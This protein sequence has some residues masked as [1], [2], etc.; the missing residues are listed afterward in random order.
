MDVWE[1]RGDKGRKER[2]GGV[3]RKGQGFERKERKMGGL[4]GNRKGK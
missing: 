2:K 4:K 3:K 1:M